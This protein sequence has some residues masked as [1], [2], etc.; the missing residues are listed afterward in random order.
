MNGADW[1]AMLKAV[2]DRL[3][4]STSV[5]LART[6]PVTLA[7]SAPVPVSAVPTG[8]SLTAVRTTASLAVAVAVPSVTV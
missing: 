5:S 2:T 8:V 7:S 1:P 4:A 6:L 3:V